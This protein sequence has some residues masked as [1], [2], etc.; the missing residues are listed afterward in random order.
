M[1]VKEHGLNLGALSNRCTSSLT[2]RF[3]R[4]VVFMITGSIFV[5]LFYHNPFWNL[6]NYK[7]LRWC[8]KT[9]VNRQ[10]FMWTEEICVL[11]FI[12]LNGHIFF[13]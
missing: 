6:K 1:K 5:K 7:R 8:C 9:D 4:F 2:S 13:F 10:I 3:S 11:N 12:T